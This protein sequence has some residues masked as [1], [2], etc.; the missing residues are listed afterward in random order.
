M[1]T[2]G[3][4]LLE[5]MIVLCI[6]SVLSLLAYPSWQHIVLR[7]HRLEAKLALLNL[8]ARLEGYAQRHGSYT[9]ASLANLGVNPL[10]Q[11]G[12]YR[13]VMT[14]LTAGEYQL[15]AVAR[16]GQNRDKDYAVF[17]LDNKNINSS[18]LWPS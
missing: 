9:G 8:S 13:L 17:T 7:S 1:K 12:H 4:S 15:Q 2:A 3:F 6:V 16:G 10:T 14:V 11:Q 5:L 18:V